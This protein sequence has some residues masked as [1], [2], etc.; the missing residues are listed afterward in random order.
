MRVLLA[1]VL[2]LALP[3][4]AFAYCRGLDVGQPGY[5]PNFYSIEQEFGRS[6]YVAMATVERAA[7][8]NYAGKR[9]KG[10]PTDKFGVF[11]TLRIER[12]FK[13]HPPT[14]LEVFSED[15]NARFWLEPSKQYLV[16]LSFAKFDAPVG[17]ALTVDSCGNTP[18]LLQNGASLE[19]R[20]SRLGRLGFKQI[21]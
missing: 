21:R 7:W 18:T 6:K 13:G 17:S 11:F 5:D 3:N 20:L 12:S 16:M 2:T 4:A 8:L 19:R 14:H 15:S 10:E 9:Q 1:A